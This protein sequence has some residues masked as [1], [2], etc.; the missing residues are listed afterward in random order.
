MTEPF[1]AEIRMVAFN[2]A[3]RGWALCNGQLLPINQ[4]QALFSLLGTTYGG[5]GQTNFALPDLRG[6]S[7]VHAGQGRPPVSLGQRGGEENHTLISSEM[8]AHTHPVK[9][10]AANASAST[11]TG[12]VWAASTNNPFS[13]SAPDTA[14][15][16]A[17]VGAAGGSQPH[18]NLQPYTVVNFVIALLGSSP[19]A[20]RLRRTRRRTKERTMSDPFI[21]EIRMFGGNFAPRGWAFCNGQLLS[22]AQNTALF[23]LLG[24]TY[25]GDGQDHVRPAGSAGPLA[26]APG[27]GPRP[28]ARVSWAKPAVRQSVTLL[29]SQMPAHTHQPQADA[30][31]GGQTSPANATWGAGGRGRPPAY[32]A[33]PAP[34]AALSPRRWR[35]PGAASRTTTVRP[36]WG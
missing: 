33:N 19:R 15:N 8:P 24:T 36:I 7:P 13:S 35:R 34:A 11:P 23:S 10:D 9:G 17:S 31:G 1:I 3:P 29:A 20:T 22:I 30:S 21:A 2:F 5:N 6:R 28:D 4:N 25:G 27:A 12:N 14:L 16:P 26:D 18:P 32:A